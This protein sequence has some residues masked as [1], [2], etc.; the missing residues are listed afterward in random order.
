MK[1]GHAVSKV[2]EGEIDATFA[3]L[4][5]RLRKF[6]QFFGEEFMERVKQRTPVVTGALRNSWGFTMRQDDIEIWSTSPYS[7]FVENGT[8]TMAP[9]GMLRTTLL[10]KDDIARVAIEKSQR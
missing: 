8:E 10:E 4:N 5:T 3:G 1:K 7:D 9:R 2:F 6:K